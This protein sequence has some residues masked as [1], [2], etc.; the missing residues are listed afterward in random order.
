VDPG[1]Q[2]GQEKEEKEEK[3]ERE[4]RGREKAMLDTGR[5]RF[6]YFDLDDT[7][8]DHRQAERDA[9]TDCCRRYP[10]HL[11]HF[12][13]DRVHDIY[14]ENNV[15]LWRAYAAGE[16]SRDDVQKRRFLSLVQH[17]EVTGLDS[18]E[19]G[20]FYLECYSR[21]WCWRPGAEQAFR[22]IAEI[23]P[24]G[25]LTNGFSDLQHAKLD[26]FPILR[27][28]SHT[29]VVSEDVGVLKP[30]R[31]IFDHAAD[32]ASVASENLLYVGDSLDSDVRGGLSAGWQVA[33]LTQ[34]SESADGAF[35]FEHWSELVAA[36]G[37]PAVT[38]ARADE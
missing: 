8:L 4:E 19:L 9:L 1:D 28:K 6:V 23:F 30:D 12:E 5:I 21:R 2:G 25:I 33:W 26:R 34:G 32:V 14:H 16:I 37:G 3:E 22:V 29:V 17:L 11:A 36:L 24:L 7:L 18:E 27:Q 20:S 10:A 35:A 15:P 13:I 38:K 31:R